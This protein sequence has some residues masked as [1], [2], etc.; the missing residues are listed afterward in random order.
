MWTY[1]GILVDKNGEK[2]TAYASDSQTREIF[3]GK[4]GE[5]YPFF[6][7]KNKKDMMED[8]LY[9]VMVGYGPANSFQDPGFYWV[10]RIGGSLDWE[11]EKNVRP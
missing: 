4:N 8:G 2:Y 6:V 10:K 5:L 9:Q 3:V 7:E 1:D 11:D